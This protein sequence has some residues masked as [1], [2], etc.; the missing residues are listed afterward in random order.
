MKID[1]LTILWTSED[2]EIALNMLLMYTLKSNVNHWW[3]ECNLITW[4]PSNKLLCSNPEVQVMVKQIM[5]AGVKVYSCKRCA[6]EYGL[7]EQLEKMGIEVKLMGEPFTEY[8]QD[9][10]YRVISI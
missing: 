8:L 9:S 7:T 6:D 4:G 10:S 2:E 5:E 1:K 3:K